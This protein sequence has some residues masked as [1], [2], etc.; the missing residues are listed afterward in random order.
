M[1][2]NFEPRDPERLSHD[3]LVVMVLDLQELVRQLIAADAEATCTIAQQARR[4]AE[5][6]REAGRSSENSGKPPSGDKNKDKSAREARKRVRKDTKKRRPGKQPGSPGRTLKRTDTPDVTVTHTPEQCGSCGESLAEAPVVRSQ[7][8]QVFDVPDPELVVTDHVALTRLCSCGVETQGAFP[9]EATAPACWGPNVRSYAVYLLVYQHIPYERC[10]QLLCDLLGAKVS[11]GALAGWL[12]Q[13]AGC[14]GGFEKLVRMLLR[15][16][17]I[18]HADETTIRVH[19]GQDTQ[20]ETDVA[21][22]TAA[23]QVDTA[24]GETVSL[25]TR[26]RRQRRL[27]RHS[28]SARRARV[29]HKKYVHVASTER[30]TWLALHDGRGRKAMAEIGIL[31]HMTGTLVSDG[32]QAYWDSELNIAAHATC[33]AHILRNLA[34]VAEVAGQ[35]DWADAMID[36]L[37]DIHDAT[38]AVSNGHLTDAKDP[39]ALHPDTLAAFESRYRGIL[40]VGYIANPEPDRRKRDQL[41]RESFNLVKRL[42]KHQHE[43]LHFAHDFTIPYSNNLAERDL[44]TSKLHD[45]ISG[46]YRSVA[47]AHAALRLRSYISTLAKNGEALLPAIRRALTGDPWLPTTA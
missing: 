40:A 42:D 28:R 25:R 41:E 31:P 9:P 6:E 32:Y 20:E 45:K 10:A 39:P 47:H 37:C 15:T 46:T 43:V 21:A 22:E 12:L 17:R 3:E 13:A 24:G 26:K 1:E 35:A 18:V 2:A 5:L 29:R 38:I 19:E 30:L 23:E 44:R 27:A 33:N 11:T 36:L 7:S 16:A 34:S 8:R 14:L 4:I